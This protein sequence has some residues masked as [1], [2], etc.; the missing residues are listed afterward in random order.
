MFIQYHYEQGLTEAQL[1]D[2]T[3]QAEFNWIRGDLYRSGGGPG[4]SDKPGA[5]LIQNF[6]SRIMPALTG[7]H[8]HYAPETIQ[9]WRTGI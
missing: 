2:L 6:N 8:T 3:L 4:F 5:K 7:E 9:S 1:Q